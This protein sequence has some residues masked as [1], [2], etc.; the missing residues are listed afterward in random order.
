MGSFQR[1]EAR[2]QTGGPVILDGANGT[3]LQR[4]SW[5]AAAEWESSTYVPSQKDC[6]ESK[7]SPSSRVG[8]GAGIADPHP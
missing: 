6:G 1:L 8:T 7:V 3:E 4:R 5:A 2:L